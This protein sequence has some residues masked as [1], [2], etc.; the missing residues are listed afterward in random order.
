MTAEPYASA[1]K[2]WQRFH[3]GSLLPGGT[4]A[5]PTLSQWLSLLRLSRRARGEPEVH[6]VQIGANRGGREPNEWVR[7]ALAENPNWSATVV[8]PVDHLFADLA[9]NYRGW[10]ER[11]EPIHAAVATYTGRCEMFISSHFSTAELSTL[12]LGEQVHGPRCFHGGR[13][14]NYVRTKLEEGKLTKAN[15]SCMTLE[16]LLASRRRR[17]PVDL[18]TLDTEMFDYTLLRSIRFDRT[19]PLAIE[20][21]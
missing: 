9:A 17:L 20:F 7:V 8:E 19:R 3:R 2:N 6:I 13:A 14:C 10:E 4:G 21:E 11:V 15:V 12:A 16:D 1:N 5:I 18:L